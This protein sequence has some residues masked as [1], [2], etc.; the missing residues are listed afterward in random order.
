MKE[1]SVQREEVV[2]IRELFQ[3]F[4]CVLNNFENV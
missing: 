2:K 3:R 4:K 1:V